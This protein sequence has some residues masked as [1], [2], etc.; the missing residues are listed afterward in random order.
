MTSGKIFLILF[1]IPFMALGAA[2]G[3]VYCSIA[4]G[5]VGITEAIMTVLRGR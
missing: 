2:L 1:M 5:F 3:F 4:A